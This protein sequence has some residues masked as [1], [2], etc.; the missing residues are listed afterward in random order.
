MA[1]KKCRECGNN[2]SSSADKCPSCGCPTKQVTDGVGCLF[3]VLVIYAFFNFFGNDYDN[4]ITPTRT[5]SKPSK[6]T[7]PRRKKKIV[8][9]N[10]VKIEIKEQFDSQDGSHKNII[11]EIKQLIV[12][13]ES[14]KHIKTTYDNKGSYLIVYTDFYH[15]NGFGKIVENH[16]KAKVDLNGNVLEVMSNYDDEGKLII[17]E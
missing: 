7:K 2:V 6:I 14:F 15:K 12:N 9:K 13:P 17:V 4:N 1:L 10:P 5:Y 16:H 11:K 3:I 8:K